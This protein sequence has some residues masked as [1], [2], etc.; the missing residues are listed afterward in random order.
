MT[1]DNES[2]VAWFISVAFACFPISRRHIS[3]EYFIYR[4]MVVYIYTCARIFFTS[5]QQFGLFFLGEAR[6]KSGRAFNT[7]CYYSWETML[8][9]QTAYKPSRICIP[10]L[11]LY[12]THVR[13][14]MEFLSYI[15]FIIIIWFLYFSVPFGEK[16]CF[17]FV[18]GNVIMHG[19]NA[20]CSRMH[21][22]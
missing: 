12:T 16:K 7:V 4:C 1:Y 17:F 20:K 3:Q 21:F 14:T 11:G 18:I 9:D 8:P 10:H 5:L 15:K 13:L 6:L 22:I 2:D 19:C